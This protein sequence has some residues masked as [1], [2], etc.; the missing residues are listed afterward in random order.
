MN[1]PQTPHPQAPMGAPPVKKKGSG[2]LLAVGIVAAVLGVIFVVG[3][4]IVYRV[5]KSPEGQK[6][7]TLIGE[8]S[9]AMRDGL[10]APG[11]TELKALGCTQP[12]VVDAEKMVALG[13]L[14]GADAGTKSAK[15][16][17]SVTVVCQVS[18]RA[19]AP[20]CDAVASTYVAAAA[21]TSSFLVTLQ[22]A[23]APEAGCHAV[24]DASGAKLRDARPAR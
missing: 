14:L 8:G 16:D 19:A 6:A 7:V 18:K 10:N 24:Y 21:P 9:K 22:V 5:V 3:A 12:M 2:C 1:Y 15:P 23:G 11:T 20:T 13:Q 4:F 17:F